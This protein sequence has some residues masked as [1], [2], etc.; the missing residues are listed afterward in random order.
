MNVL[1][2]KH[3]K[4]WIELSLSLSSRKFSLTFSSFCHFDT[5]SLINKPANDVY[6]RS[7]LPS[8]FFFLY[9]SFRTSFCPLSERDLG[10]YLMFVLFDWQ[11]K[12]FE[13]DV[14]R[15]GYSFFTP[16]PYGVLT[17]GYLQVK[18]VTFSILC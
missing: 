17:I 11:S 1:N 2:D 4:K 18:F 6:L 15:N 9:S 12:I 13:Q 16:L 8:F 14:Y 10:I 7:S 5:W 3:I